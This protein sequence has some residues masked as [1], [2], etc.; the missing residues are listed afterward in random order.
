MKG[1][2]QMK[3]PVPVPCPS[4][5]LVPVG[6]GTLLLLATRWAHLFSEVAPRLHFRLCLRQEGWVVLS[7]L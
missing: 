6:A 2:G 5:L 4:L 3:G 7:Q 1:W